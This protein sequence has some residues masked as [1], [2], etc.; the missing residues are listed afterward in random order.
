VREL[1][2]A[3]QRLSQGSLLVLGQRVPDLLQACLECPE[4]AL[5]SAVLAALPLLAARPMVAGWA[6]RLRRPGDEVRTV[7]RGVNWLDDPGVPEELRAM[8]AEAIQDVL[9]ELSIADREEWAASVQR[10]LTGSAARLW[11]DLVAGSARPR[12]GLRPWAKG[13]K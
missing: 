9:A 6:A 1:R 13:G 7:V 3:L 8:I 5:G 12:R 2:P 4:P 11:T 10:M